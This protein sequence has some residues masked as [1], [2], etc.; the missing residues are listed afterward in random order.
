MED[1]LSLAD[2]RELQ[3]SLH[4]MGLLEADEAVTLTPLTGGVS[5]QIVRVETTRSTLCI[6][7]ALSRLKVAAE[8]QAPVE[9]NEAEVAWMRLAGALIPGCVPEILGEDQVSR[10]F[11]MRYLD[12][13]RYAVWKSQLR[14]GIADI[15]V[16]RAVGQKLAAVHRGTAHDSELAAAFSNDASFHALRLEPYFLTAAS[17][18]PD[19]AGPLR[20]LTERTANTR[21]ALVHGD[22][23]PK[24]ILVGPDGPVFL[25]AECAWYGDPA[26]DLSF[27]LAHLLLKC[28]WVPQAASGFLQCFDALQQAYLEGLDWEPRHDLEAR[29]AALLPALLLAR[30]DGKSP[31]EYIT[32]DAQRRQI[33]A[34]AK[35]RVI[36]APTTLASIHQAWGQE[37]A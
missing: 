3:A 29:A 30:V 2:E 31:V 22:V 25:D 23:S 19:C 11:A 15:A 4:R 12:P 27:C 13:V 33:R 9:R 10:A 35:S 34:F 37:F 26:F 28:A 18:N 21:L 8:W 7:R 20:R 32:Q 1:V 14:D 16:A 6:K 24:N 5:S 36:V 17:A